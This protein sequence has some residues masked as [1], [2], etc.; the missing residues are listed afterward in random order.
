MMESASSVVGV[1]D[2]DSPPP[3]G[4][5]ERAL[6]LAHWHF[7]FE[8]PEQLPMLE[9]LYHDDIVWEVPSRRVIHRG[10]KDV[11]ENYAK[12]FESCA[13]PKVVLV[14]RYGTP[15]RVFDDLEMTFKLIDGKGFPNHPLPVGTRIALRVVHNFHIQDGLIIRENGYEMWRPDISW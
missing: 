15:E 14:E 10:K 6:W 8:N 3:V 12:I 2:W 7:Q 4:T 5:T 13:E 9:R 11:L 1:A